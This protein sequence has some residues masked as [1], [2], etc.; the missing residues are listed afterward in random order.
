M[1]INLSLKELKEIKNIIDFLICSKIDQN[2]FLNRDL[3]DK[4]ANEIEYQE[5]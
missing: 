4:I 5:S 2:L 1:L 3:Y